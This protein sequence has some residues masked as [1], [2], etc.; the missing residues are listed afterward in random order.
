[1]NAV[2]KGVVGFGLISVPVKM[3]SAAREHEVPLRLLHRETLQPIRYVR[4][5][6]GCA[7]EVGWDDIVRGYEYEEGRYVTFEKE[8]LEELT[9]DLTRDF[10]IREF[11]RLEEVDPIHL[12]KTYYLSPEEGGT[13]AYS[14]LAKALEETGKAGLAVATIRTKARPALIRSSGGALLLTTLRYKEE[15]VPTENVPG[16]DNIPEAGRAEVETAKLLIGQLTADFDPGQ[17]ED[18]SYQ[19]L[20]EAIALKI[21]GGQPE[22]RKPDTRQ[23]EPEDLMEALRSSLELFKPANQTDRSGERTTDGTR[24]HGGSKGANKEKGAG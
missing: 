14:L 24:K 8:E 5:C 18:E 10:R 3:Y 6:E 21:D 22:I 17:F 20:T 16:L 11:V 2:W 12:Y 23:A 15:I 7:D 19:R 4:T 1:M 9:A 13:R